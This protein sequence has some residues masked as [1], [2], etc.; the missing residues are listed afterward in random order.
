MGHIQQQR[1]HLFFV[2]VQWF[3]GGEDGRTAF[4]EVQPQIPVQTLSELLTC[5]DIRWE[6][7]DQKTW[8]HFYQTGNFK[9]KWSGTQIAGIQSNNWSWRQ[10]LACSFIPTTQMDILTKVTVLV[11]RRQFIGHTREE[12]EGQPARN[13]SFGKLLP[14]VFID[15]LSLFY[16]AWRK[17]TT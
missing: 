5:R 4:T 11:E 15:L 2:V 7:E 9:Y 16:T 10:L 8:L 1:C 12:V 14:G 6:G 17:K 3:E 13:Q